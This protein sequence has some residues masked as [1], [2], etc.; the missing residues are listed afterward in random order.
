MAASVIC[1]WFPLMEHTPRRLP[2]PR[3]KNN[4]PDGSPDGNSLVFDVMPP[5]G[6]LETAEAYIVTRARRG[7]PWGTPRQLTTHG[8]SDPKWSP[9]GR[10]IAFCAGGAPRR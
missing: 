6:S 5:G 8:S 1:L 2:R 7:A 3:V 9:D 10:L 4:M